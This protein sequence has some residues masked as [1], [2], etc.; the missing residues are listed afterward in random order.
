MQGEV[1]TAALP[2]R[3]GSDPDIIADDRSGMYGF[4]KPHTKRL[5]G[6]MIKGYTTFRLCT[7]SSATPSGF[8]L[9]GEDCRSLLAGPVD[10]A[11]HLS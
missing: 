2:R 3:S 4:D 6:M 10:D 9:S 7:A 11:A 1:A 5:S 8:D